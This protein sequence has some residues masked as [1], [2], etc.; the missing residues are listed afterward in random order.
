[1]QVKPAPGEA[2]DH[3]EFEIVVEPWFEEDVGRLPIGK[4]SRHK[5]LPLADVPSNSEQIN[6]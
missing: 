4:T 5:R 3:G 1:V 6:E 2:F